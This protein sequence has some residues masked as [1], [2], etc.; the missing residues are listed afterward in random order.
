MAKPD[1]LEFYLETLG[2]HSLNNGRNLRRK[3]IQEI[4]AKVLRSEILG[5]RNHRTFS[6]ENLAK[7]FKKAKLTPTLEEGRNLVR[8]LYL[9]E[10]NCG[11]RGYMFFEK[12]DKKRILVGYSS[13][14]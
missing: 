7:M 2:K 5:E 6:C 12:V 3:D 11:S 13:Y 4:G 10:A 1:S 9:D 14:E 8:T